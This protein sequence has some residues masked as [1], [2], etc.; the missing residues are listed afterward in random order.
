MQQSDQ[1]TP[2][3][4]QEIKLS[5]HFRSASDALRPHLS[6]LP[7]IGVIPSFLVATYS[8]TLPW[9]K[10]RV[11]G[12][13]GISKSPEAVLL[14]IIT[15]AGMVAATV[16]A[17][18]R[19]HRLRIAALVHLSLGLLMCGVSFAAY[20]MVLGAGKRV[21]GIP[22]ASVHP[23]PGWRL[24]AAAAI[25]VVLLAGLELWVARKRSR[26]AGPRPV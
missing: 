6:Y 18:M 15:M 5:K 11:M 9:A 17:A 22:L 3:R 7:L 21:L 14:V 20:R 25:G 2:G 4:R 12:V 26:S 1:S 23:G 24:F 13:M 8:L 10:A 16:A 19:G